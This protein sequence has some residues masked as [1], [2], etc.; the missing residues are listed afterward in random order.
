MR[1]SGHTQAATI[2]VTPLP[3]TCVRF[4]FGM[5]RQIKQ[6]PWPLIRKRYYTGWATDTCRR[7]LVPTFVVIGLSRGQRGGFPAVVNL[8][9]L[10]QSRYFSFKYLL[11]YPHKGWVDPVPDSLLLRNSGSVGNQTR[12]LWVNGQELWPLDHI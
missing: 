2:F 3:N 11:I 5:N 12:D 7:N 9:F 10:D 1:A 8:N 6:T 4:Y